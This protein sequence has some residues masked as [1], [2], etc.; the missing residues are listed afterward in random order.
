MSN[1]FISV[2]TVLG[3]ASN[4][5]IVPIVREKMAVIK[6]GKNTTP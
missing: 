5:K 1:H 6:A 4:A 2:Q 3:G